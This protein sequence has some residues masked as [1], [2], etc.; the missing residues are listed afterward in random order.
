M[1]RHFSTDDET[2]AVEVFHF[3][4]ATHQATIQTTMDVE[5]IIEQNKKMMNQGDSGY[6][7][8]REMKRIASIPNEVLMT[9]QMRYGVD[10]LKKENVH[11]LKRLLNDPEWK[12]LRTA[13]G[14]F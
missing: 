11:L 13:P 12:Y 1:K 9:W 6:S 5:P 3:D 10:V 2:G 4:D 8:S 14:R 7:P